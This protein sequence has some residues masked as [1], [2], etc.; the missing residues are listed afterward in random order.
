MKTATLPP[1]RIPPQLRAELDA[2]LQQ[3][4]SV[5]AFVQAAVEARIAERRSEAD[6]IARAWAAQ[7]KLQAGGAHHA[8]DAVMAELRALRP[9]RPH[10]A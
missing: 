6:F 10:A 3:G 9:A 5:S 4:E 2:A 1:V 8:P 7:A